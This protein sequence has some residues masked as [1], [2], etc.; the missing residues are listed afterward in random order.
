MLRKTSLSPRRRV[1]SSTAAW[2]AVRCTSV[3][4][5]P[6]SPISS[7]PYSSGGA[8]R[9]TSTC[10]PRRSRATTSG[11]RCSASSS[12]AVRTPLSRRTRVR[13]TRNATSTETTTATS[14]S[15]PGGG[16]PD[17]DA[18][19]HRHRTVGESVGLGQFEVP[20]LLLH[21]VVAGL[22]GRRVDRR[23]AGPVGHDQRVLHAAQPGERLAL[24][25][26][27][28]RDPAALGQVGHG[29]L[30]EPPLVA[31]GLHELGVLPL[32]EPSGGQRAGQQRVGL[33]EQFPGAAQRGERQRLPVE[34]RVGQGR[35]ARRTPGRPRRPCRCRGRSRRPGPPC[36]R[37]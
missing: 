1:T 13:P 7:W 9:A 8:S 2:T 32:G 18:D 34:V 3:K 31:D 22:P 27:L 12:A 4:A 29:A 17:Q 28:V 14:P 11:S 5:R 33:A 10:S 23:P 16:Q 36:G 21:R 26:S 19:R 35:H 24:G 25:Q 15:T 20:Q 6:T 30:G 37:R